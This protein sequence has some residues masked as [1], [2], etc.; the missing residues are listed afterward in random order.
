LDAAEAA[1]VGEK[2]A[3]ENMFVQINSPLSSRSQAAQ[4]DGAVLGFTAANGT[5]QVLVFVNAVSSVT[6]SLLNYFS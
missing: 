2:A 5:A 6:I 3:F 1:C 4:L